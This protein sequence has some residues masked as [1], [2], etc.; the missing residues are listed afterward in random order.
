MMKNKLTQQVID[1]RLEA[2]G[3]KDVNE[4]DTD[5]QL[6]IVLDHF[7]AEITH[8]FM[9]GQIKFYE[10]TTADG[11]SIYIATENPD[12]VSICDDVFYYE[13]D[14]FSKFEDA[15]LDGLNIYIDD[16]DM[17]DYGL[18]DQI[19][20]VYQRY[21]REMQARVEQELIEE[22]YEQAE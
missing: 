17:G 9:N 13:S 3:V 5:E 6:S 22:G 21:Y 7:D 10:E 8:D 14:R 4:L 15:V 20:R 1:E 2:K 19:E 11:Y 16:Y 18:Q 12:N